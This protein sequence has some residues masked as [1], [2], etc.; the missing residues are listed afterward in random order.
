MRLS[1]EPFAISWDH[2]IPL[3]LRTSDTRQGFWVTV[4][5]GDRIGRGE[6]TPLPDG[7]EDLLDRT[8]S[9][10]QTIA[11][12][13]MG[14]Q[15]L[16]PFGVGVAVAQ[17]R[18]EWPVSAGPVLTQGLLWGS[19]DDMADQ[20]RIKRDQGMICFK[21]KVRQVDDWKRVQA[22]AGLLPLGGSFRLDANRC[23]DLDEAIALAKYLVDVPI[24]YIEEPLRN[25]AQ[26][27][28]FYAQT[29]MGV[30]LDETLYL[31][32]S[33]QAFDGLKAL[34]MKP[35][36]MKWQQFQSLVTTAQRLGIPMVW[37]SAFES[38]IGLQIVKECAQR[39]SPGIPAGVD[40]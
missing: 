31:A 3:G 40:V 23:F 19:P 20:L 2:P 12:N 30:A 11:S 4:Q 33:W 16:W 14:T 24:D 26:L 10:I 9:E 25:P 6:V 8:M 5:S 7:S 32:E 39:Y 28:D 34:V 29:G 15:D 37:S 17:C 1:W 18:G 36:L 22:L 13:L 38:P 35:T 27:H 21:I